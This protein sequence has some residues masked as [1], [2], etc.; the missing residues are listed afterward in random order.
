MFMC[1]STGRLDAEIDDEALVV[2]FSKNL[3]KGKIEVPFC[4]GLIFEFHMFSNKLLRDTC[5]RG[6]KSYPKL[7]HVGPTGVIVKVV[8]LQVSILRRGERSLKYRQRLK[9][10]SYT[11]IKEVETRWLM[12][13]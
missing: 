4:V 11:H 10:D 7:S 5:H 3:P 8:I 2:F 9:G 6:H 13:N 1:I 12:N